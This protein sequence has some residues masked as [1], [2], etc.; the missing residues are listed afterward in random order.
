MKTKTIKKI[1]S[2]KIN[3]WL[4]SI[5]DPVVKNACK[6]DLIVTGGSIASMLL[7]QDVNDFDIYFKT[8]QTVKI[9]SDYYVKQINAVYKNN[10][11]DSKILTVDR[12]YIPE[13]DY[14]NGDEYNKWSHFVQ[15]LE[16][17]EEKRIKIYIPHI[18][19]WRRNNKDE[20][21]IAEQEVK[22][23][24]FTPIY[25]TENAITLSD[26]IQLV[27]RFFGNV[28]QIHEN[29]DF[30]HAT[31][32]FHVDKKSGKNTLVLRTEAMESI[33]TKELI[34]IG[35]KYPLTSVIRTKKFILRGFTISAG[36]YLKML[37]QVAEL[38]LKDPI[39]LQ[40]QLIGVDI[41][42]FSQL[43]EV[44]SQVEPSKLTYNYISTIIDRVFNESDQEI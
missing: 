12:D 43:I 23:N 6:Q 10:I 40:E 17:S 25:L 1:I 14:T 44:L 24:S 26:D 41:A 36:T 28:E 27:I 33:L 21:T 42:Y 8:K 35:S 31:S 30:A 19:Y 34:Y 15:G 11:S 13:M 5:E 37:W 39:V 2:E 32:Y 16:R 18:G 20:S 7:G 4:E 38:D 9:V 3:N 29:Y 22:E